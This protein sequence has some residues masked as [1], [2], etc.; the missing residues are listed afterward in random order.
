MIVTSQDLAVP[1]RCSEAV[2]IPYR[3][4]VVR[5]A[6]NVLVAGR[7]FYSATHDAHASVRSMALCMAMGQARDGGGVA[8]GWRRR[9][10]CHGPRPARP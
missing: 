10:R 7:C 5:D 1:P 9:R 6:A 2:D 4:L 3:A 8:S